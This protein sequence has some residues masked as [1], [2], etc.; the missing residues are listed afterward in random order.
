MRPHL[1]VAGLH[2]PFVAT[3][4]G[5]LVVCT[6]CAT[7]LVY[8]A[9]AFMSL[10]KRPLPKRLQMVLRALEWR[11]VEVLISKQQ[12]PHTSSHMIMHRNTHR[13]ILYVHLSLAHLYANGCMCRM[14]MCVYLP[15]F[16]CF[17][18]GYSAGAFKAHISANH[19]QG[20][21]CAPPTVN[22][23]KA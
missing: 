9:L 18:F 13:H 10:G 6:Q 17:S 21:F 8:R 15:V 19:M 4:G 16:V 7:M 2:Q 5:P 20:T 1:V 3:L 11:A 12:H 23:L 14:C 22:A